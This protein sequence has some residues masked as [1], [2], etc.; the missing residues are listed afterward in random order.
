MIVR[1]I[2]LSLT[3]KLAAMELG[4]DRYIFEGKGEKN[5]AVEA[6]TTISLFRK[7]VKT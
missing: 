5:A 3:C 1:S 7:G 4:A 6:A 2:W